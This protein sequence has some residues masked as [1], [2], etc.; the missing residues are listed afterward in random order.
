MEV[1]YIILGQGI[2]GTLFSRELIKRGK[3]LIVIDEIQQYSASRV[4]SGIIN[5]ITGKRLA[6]LP[7]L[8]HYLSVAKH[9]YRELEKELNTTLVKQFNILN[10]HSSSVSRDVFDEKSVTEQEYLHRVER[11]EL[12]QEYFEF[13][14]GIGEI[15]PC[16]SIDVSNLLNKWRKELISKNILVAE[17]FDWNDCKVL[18]DR[19]IYKDV[20]AR[21]IICCEGIAGNTNP[22]FSSLP[23]TQNK[24]EIIIAS[25]P[26]LSRAS[27]YRQDI[28]VI[29]WKDDLFWIGPSFEWKFDTLEPTIA[30]RKTV[31]DKLDNWLKLPYTIV[32]HWVSQR[33]TTLDHVPFAGG[34]PEHPSIAILNGFGSK[35]CL[36]APYYAQHFACHLIDNTPLDKDVDIARLKPPRNK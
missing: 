19:A 20:I 27:I 7:N 14:H 12:W 29:P 16:W 17:K 28:N 15:S 5:P 30:F 6:K 35:G 18:E 23:F 24:G 26:R 10:F 3:S 32:D 13:E 25:I 33:P 34:H 21:K 1:D 31:T 8:E 11:E 36:W 2:A 22:Y 9:T 4:T